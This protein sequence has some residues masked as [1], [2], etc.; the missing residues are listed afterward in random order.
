MCTWHLHKGEGY[1][2]NM[3][4]QGHSWSRFMSIEADAPHPHPN[5]CSTTDGVGFHVSKAPAPT[6]EAAAQQNSGVN[7]LD[8]SSMVTPYAGPHLHGALWHDAHRL[9]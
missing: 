1:D 6:F 7:Q 2:T 9:C 4:W 5:T 3:S 8:E